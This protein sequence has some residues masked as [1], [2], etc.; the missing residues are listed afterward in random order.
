MCKIVLSQNS[1]LVPDYGK[2]FKIVSEASYGL[3]NGGAPVFDGIQSGIGGWASKES[4]YYMKTSHYT[5]DGGYYHAFTPNENMSYVVPSSGYLAIS[6]SYMPWYRSDLA[7][8]NRPIYF[9]VALMRD[10][11]EYDIASL[12]VAADSLGIAKGAGTQVPVRKGDKIYWG[13]L[14]EAVD[15]SYPQRNICEYSIIFY[16]ALTISV[17]SE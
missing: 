5:S 3:P 13:G 1:V 8:G 9:W 7:H 2:P 4:H 15:T 16:P 17:G 14:L 11:H 12:Y 6:L 10:S